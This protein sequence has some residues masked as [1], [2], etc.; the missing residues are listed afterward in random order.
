[1]PSSIVVWNFVLTLILFQ[2]IVT[3]TTVTELVADYWI[4]LSTSKDFSPEGESQFW[5]IS[6]FRTQHFKQQWKGKKSILGLECCLAFLD[7]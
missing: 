2:Y 5:R 1:M 4:S 7:V 6:Y 3:M